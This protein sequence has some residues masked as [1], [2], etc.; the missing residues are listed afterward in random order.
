MPK[1]AEE[2]VYDNQPKIDEK[3]RT[4]VS[5]ND[6]SDIDPLVKLK[7]N[8]QTNQIKSKSNHGIHLK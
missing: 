5:V 2:L 1:Y 6:Q 8:L 3:L 7:R 4:E